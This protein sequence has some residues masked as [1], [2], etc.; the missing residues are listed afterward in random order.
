GC[1]GSKWGRDRNV[2]SAFV[3][4][5][6]LEEG[7]GRAVAE[8]GVRT[9]AQDGGHPMAELADPRPTDGVDP[10]EKL[11][12]AALGEPVPDRLRS[13]AEIEQLTARD[14]A[15]LP[16]DQRPDGWLRILGGHNP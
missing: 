5:S 8:E 9:A 11:V 14:H 10:R 16:R 6:D 7:P 1:A 3:A 15:V 13:E 4:A 2:D 12:K